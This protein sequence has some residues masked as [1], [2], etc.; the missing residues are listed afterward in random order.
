[1]SDQM[2]KLSTTLWSFALGGLAGAL[3]VVML[4][5]FGGFGWNGAVFTGALLALALG[6]FL[7]AVLSR[8]LP[9]M[10]EVQAR[11][12]AR[13]RELGEILRRVVRRTHTPQDVQRLVREL[14]I[15]PT[16]P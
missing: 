9:T 3:A 8:P 6:G 12:A 13:E 2:G 11:A 16:L 15:A 4:V 7:A 1:M 5:F 10:A 14:D